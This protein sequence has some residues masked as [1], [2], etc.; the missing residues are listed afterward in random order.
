MC[1]CWCVTEINCR[2]YLIFYKGG[3][4]PNT[5]ALVPGIDQIKLRNFTASG[6]AYFSPLM[7]K[8]FPSVIHVEVCTCLQFCQ[9]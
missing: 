2:H 6:S 4:G 5:D 3:N 1:I 8:C 9:I 7:A